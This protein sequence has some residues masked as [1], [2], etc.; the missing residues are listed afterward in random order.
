MKVK[1]MIALLLAL[2]LGLC[3]LPCPRARAAGPFTDVP[4]NA[5]YRK[6]VLWAYEEK[7]TAGTSST[8]FSP[9]SKLSFAEIAT[10]L[11]RYAYSPTAHY[12]QPALA[13]WRGQYYYMPL[14]WCCDFGLI[15]PAQVS[16][17]NHPKNK[18]TRDDFVEI[19]YRYATLWE[20]RP[21]DFEADCLAPYADAPAEAEARRA[22][23]WAVSA[24]I[25]RGT[26]AHSLSPQKQLNRAEFVTM[27]Y[28][29]E[30]Q[31]EPLRGEALMGRRLRGWQR[32]LL[33]AGELAWGAPWVDE[34]Y[35]LGADGIPTVI[36]C[37]GIVNWVFRYT[38]LRPYEDMDCAPLW[39]SGIFPHVF[40]RSAGENG[41]AFFLRCQEQLLPGDL[42]LL[43]SANSGYH[44]MIYLGATA[45]E[46][47]VFHA[48][49]GKGVCAEAIPIS[50]SSG[51]IT[52]Q[53]GVMRHI[54]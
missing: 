39:A 6:P 10:F 32:T 54:P 4:E 29:F 1:R 16:G 3:A 24:G 19:L 31:A 35:V 2:W 23:S 52:K 18:L 20:K 38:G 36:D 40:E 30:T 22:W 41:L 44:I 51:Y 21:T 27:L 7:I 37:S 26:A 33:E 45:S 47:Y 48:R 25:V 5:Y 28:R 42:L 17:A 53:I 50:E 8:T 34:A 12:T 15:A 46:L 13:R 49:A 11:Y 14:S 9:K 43:H